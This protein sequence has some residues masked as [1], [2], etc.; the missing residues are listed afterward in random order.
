MPGPVPSARILLV[1]GSDEEYF[2]REWNNK[3]AFM[4]GV[5]ICR[6]R[7]YGAVIAGMRS[8]IKVTGRI[9]VGAIMDANGDTE[10]RWAQIMSGLGASG[11]GIPNQPS[12]GGTI[13]IGPMAIRIGVWLMPDNQ[14]PGEFE[15][16]IRDL[17]PSDDDTI[18]LAD[19]YVA[20]AIAVRMRFAQEKMTKAQIRAWLA[21]RR[22]PGLL[23]E[24]VKTGDL[25]LTPATLGA[26]QVWLKTLFDNAQ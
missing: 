24:A 8:E 26:F 6:R 4:T 20:D 10:S 25:E 19:R 22:E 23:G 14:S 18:A 7:G 15:H 11:T 1:E 5:D 16:F 21:V 9:A 17:I 13:W 12:P 2:L 3:P